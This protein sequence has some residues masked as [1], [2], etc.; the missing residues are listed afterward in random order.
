[1]DV[2]YDGIA[3]WYDTVAGESAE[4]S[5]MALRD[6]LGPGTGL[7][8]DLGCGTGLYFDVIASTGRIPVGADISAD[9]LRVA[10]H[11][12]RRLVQADA[13]T[14][15]FADGTFDTVTS[16]WVSTDVDDFAAVTREAS[17][18]L[19]DGG[20]FVFFGVHP[21]FNG[22]GVENRDDGARIVHPVYRQATRHRS[23]PWW[24]KDGIRT[25]VGGMRHVPLAELL[26]CIVG[27]GLR[28]TSVV[29]PGDD[30]IPAILAIRASK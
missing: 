19:S 25:R 2:R 3:D 7:C 17:R 18:V 26:N 24:G 9:Q 1:M 21:C 4:R 20:T 13:T 16:I 28:I 15:P 6:I 30:P 22:P 23:A 10:Q 27:A 8:L 14:V 5:R 12:G 29:E 11:R